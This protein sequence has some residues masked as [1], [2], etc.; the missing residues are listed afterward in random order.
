MTDAHP[1]LPLCIFHA[2]YAPDKPRI[3][4]GEN[5]VRVRGAFGQAVMTRV[6]YDYSTCG[7]FTERPSPCHYP[8]SCVY[9]TLS[10][11]NAPT[12]L[13]NVPSWATDQE[14]SP[15]HP[16]RMFLTLF[17]ASV[18][19]HRLI[20]DLLEDVAGYL[21]P[22]TDVATRLLDVHSLGL[23]GEQVQ[24]YPQTPQTPA[25]PKPI[26]MDGLQLLNTA[27]SGYGRITLRVLTPMHLERRKQRIIEPSFADIV[28][29][30]LQRIKQV[31]GLP[32]KYVFP[33]DL[34]GVHDIP[35]ELCDL[36]QHQF[37]RKRRHKAS[38]RLSGFT[39]RLSFAPVPQAFLPYLQLASVFNL[40]RKTT[41]G[42]GQMYIEYEALT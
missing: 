42:F 12:Y 39:G 10:Q 27:Q 36:Q 16:L 8:E 34:S 6:C 25:K 7:R 2:S 23:H 11:A 3:L 40:G 32:H 1:A 22:P 13:L 5:L 4:T 41:H 24:M 37:V 9:H 33:L 20:G 38:I 21:F 29:A 31:A 18:Q 28:Y 17:G 30:S 15:A 19:H 26:I 35:T 14:I